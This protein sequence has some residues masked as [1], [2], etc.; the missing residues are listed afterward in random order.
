MKS[1]GFFFFFVD[2]MKS[3]FCCWCKTFT[4]FCGDL[5]VKINNVKVYNLENYNVLYVLLISQL[6]HIYFLNIVLC[7]GILFFLF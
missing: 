7:V 5:M 6:S 4:P 3:F 1:F 2:R